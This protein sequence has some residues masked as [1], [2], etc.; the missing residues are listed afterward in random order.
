[1][2][3]DILVQW[4]R[5]EPSTWRASCV[6]LTILSFAQ[7]ANDNTVGCRK[8]DRVF[9]KYYL[10]QLGRSCPY[11]CCEFCTA[12]LCHRYPAQ[13]DKALSQPV[14]G[15]YVYSRLHKRRKQKETLQQKRLTANLHVQ[16]PGV[17]Q[18]SLQQQQKNQVPALNYQLRERI[19][20]QEQPVQTLLFGL[21]KQ[22]LQQDQQQHRQQALSQRSS[23]FSANAVSACRRT[24]SQSW[25][26]DAVNSWLTQIKPIAK[27]RA[28]VAVL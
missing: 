3:V 26:L 16:H 13:P 21:H 11:V 24:V 5:D 28:R 14:A 17:Q 23:R 7:C 8:C 6:M 18:P 22:A 2:A 1:M 9:S 15:R 19:E 12:M 4:L 20:K 27:A 25:Q 10:I